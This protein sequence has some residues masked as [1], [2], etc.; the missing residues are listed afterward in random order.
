M[1]S[2]VAATAAGLAAWRVHA[3]GDR[4]AAVCFNDSV[5]TLVPPARGAAA[6]ERVLGEIARMNATLDA[7]GPENN[8]TMLNAALLKVARIAKHDC[9]IVVL[10]DAFG[11]DEETRKLVTGLTQHNDVIAAFIYDPLEA[12]L[13]A[14]G[15]VVLAEGDTRLKVDTDA[16]SL[17]EKYARSFVERREQV[18]AFGR[19]RAIPI[20]PLSTGLDVA[21]QI[22]AALAP[23]LYP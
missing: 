17:R 2:V 5:A 23:R 10:S 8:P 11:A 6:V 15:E 4:V 19:H 18:A 22:R 13:P 1:K 20:L 16:T 14:I 7:R 12:A 21:A 3:A 9:L